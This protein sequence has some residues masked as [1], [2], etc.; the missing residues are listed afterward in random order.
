MDH[1]ASRGLVHSTA[2]RHTWV[3]DDFPGASI[4]LRS[5][6]PEPFVIADRTLS[7]VIGEIDGRNAM[8]MLHEQAIYQHA[9]MP[10]QV[11]ELDVARRR[12]VVS[13]VEPDYY[14]QPVVQS[15]MTPIET[16]DTTRHPTLDVHLGEVRIVEQVTGFKK[17]RF[18]SHE[19]LGYG[20]VDLPE[21]TMEAFSVWIELTDEGGRAA[22]EILSD[23]LADSPSWLPDGLEGLGSLVRHI[24]AIRLMCDPHDL[25]PALGLGTSPDETRPAIYL[26]EA[27]PGGVGL[28]EKLYEQIAETALDALEA[29]DRCPCEAGCPSCVGPPDRPDGLRKQTVRVI[30]EL[31]SPDVH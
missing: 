16:L 24:A 27:H 17:V 20:E 12:A 28:A 29:L 1:L 4:N 13:Q 31:L 26:H 23:R 6:G 8:R 2:E 11:E 15:S 14:T 19:N 21:L 10:Y 5:I 7:Q 18:G 25:V 30:L 3:A 9:G 22:A